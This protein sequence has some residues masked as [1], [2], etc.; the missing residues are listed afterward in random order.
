LLLAGEFG[1]TVCDIGIDHRERLIG[2][3][4]EASDLSDILWE[5]AEMN[6]L[7][8]QET[9]GLPDGISREDIVQKRFKARMYTP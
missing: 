8:L 3:D 6:R 5:K 1:K 9:Y 2:E 4:E 7:R